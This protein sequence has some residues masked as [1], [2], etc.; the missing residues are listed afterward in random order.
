MRGTEACN[1]RIW[2]GSVGANDREDSPCA[3]V[4]LGTHRNVLNVA[5][6][7]DHA[8]SLFEASLYVSHSLEDRHG[9]GRLVPQ[10]ARL[11]H[12]NVEVARLANP[13]GSG[14]PRRKP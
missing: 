2:D 3:P 13:Y 14:L 6:G 9:Q 11:P 10:H 4:V 8:S 7:T 12:A 1:E 5:T